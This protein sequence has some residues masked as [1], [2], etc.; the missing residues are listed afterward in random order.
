MIVW[1]M[2]LFLLGLHIETNGKV[3]VSEAFVSLRK[4]VIG[5]LLD[6]LTPASIILLGCFWFLNTVFNS[7]HLAV[8][9][10]A[11]L[12][13]VHICRAKQKHVFKQGFRWFDKIEH[14]FLNLLA[15]NNYSSKFF[16]LVCL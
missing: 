9:V 1:K 16:Y 11:F 7:L 8:L 2:L 15:W 6:F 13:I 12:T 4:M 5:I 3:W 14:N 10:L